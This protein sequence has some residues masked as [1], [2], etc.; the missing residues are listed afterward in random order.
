MKYLFV[1]GWSFVLLGAVLVAVGGVLATLG[2]DKLSLRSRFE[3]V[4]SGVA[5]EWEIND[6]LV[7]KDPLFASEDPNVLGSFRLYPRFHSSAVDSALG[8]GLFRP[9]NPDERAFLRALADYETV[10]ADVNAR[11]SVSDNFVLSTRDMGA[12]A[13]HRVQVKSSPG[14]AGFV[15]QHR[16][17]RAALEAEYAWALTTKFLD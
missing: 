15:A 11:L 6:V 12:I 2:W 5:R 13:D 17:L 9:S 14:F 7:R 16:K 10:I 1:Q 8:S 3:A 4:V